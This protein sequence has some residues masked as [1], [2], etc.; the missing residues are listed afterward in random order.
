M[1]TYNDKENGKSGRGGRLAFGIFMVIVYLAVGFM[2]IKD[3]FNIDNAAI[4]MTVGILLIVYGVWRGIRL[5][6]GWG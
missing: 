3:I 5:Y 6:K 1:G 4:S 2:F